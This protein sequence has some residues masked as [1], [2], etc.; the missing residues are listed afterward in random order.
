M[1]F[2]ASCNSTTCSGQVNAKHRGICPSGWHI[3]SYEDWSKLIDYVESSNGCSSCAG[4]Y[5]KSA[6]GWNSGGNG[7]DSYGFSALPGGFGSSGGHFSYVGNLGRWWSASEIFSSSA[8][9]LDMGYN[10]EYVGSSSNGKS[11][12]RSVRCVQD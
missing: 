3:P 7:E 10:S 4:T 5:L 12:L 8:Y 2:D 6:S 1:V 9:P 11:E